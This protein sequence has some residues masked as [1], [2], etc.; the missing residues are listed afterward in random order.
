MIEATWR[1]EPSSRRAIDVA[2]GILMGLR[3]CSEREAFDELA[4]A[5]HETGVGLG[6]L[7]GALA[8]LTAGVS[9]PFPHRDEAM[10]RWGHLMASTGRVGE[11]I[12]GAPD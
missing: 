2:I 1:G 8:K 7:C 11:A 3:R 12:A 10:H 9:T 4:A 6:T 5:V